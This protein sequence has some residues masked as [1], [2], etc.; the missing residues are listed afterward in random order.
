VALVPILTLAACGGLRPPVPARDPALEARIRSAVVTRLAA[1]PSLADG[2]V[3]VEV[4]GTMVLLHGSVKGLGA[5][6]CALSNAGLTP[7]V[8]SVVDF[9]TLE[10]G[11]RDVRCLAPR[12]DSTPAPRATGP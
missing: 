12:A 1:E 4:R 8:T 6:Q 2:S 10:R 5:W 9:L 3:R 7:G 11:P